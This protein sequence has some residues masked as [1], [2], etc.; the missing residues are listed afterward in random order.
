MTADREREREK[1]ECY[2]KID[3]VSIYSYLNELAQNR[4]SKTVIDMFSFE[5][6]KSTESDDDI[7]IRL[8]NMMYLI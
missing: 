8:P 2:I 5:I 3:T 6:E 4:K 1:S 7:G